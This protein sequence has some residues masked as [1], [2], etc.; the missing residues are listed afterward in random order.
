[1][2]LV[3]QTTKLASKKPWDLGTDDRRHAGARRVR[4]AD[5]CNGAAVVGRPE[6]EGRSTEQQEE[7]DMGDMNDDDKEL[8]LMVLRRYPKQLERR[9]GCPPMTTLGAENDIHTGIESP[10]KS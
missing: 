1:M 5:E 9:E 7:L 8:L 10:I 6:R 4:G 3:V 2:N